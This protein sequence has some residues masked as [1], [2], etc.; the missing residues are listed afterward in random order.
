MNQSYPDTNQSIE[1]AVRAVAQG[2]VIAYPTEAVFGIG[3]DPHHLIALE[4]ILQIK[5]RDAGKGLILIAHDQAQLTG[6]MAPVEASW[7]KQFDQYWPGP[8][9]F[10]VPVCND[11]SPALSRILTGQR[12]TIAVRVSDHPVVRRLCRDCDTALVSTSANRSGKDALRSASQVHQEFG[13]QLSVVVDA[14]VG[15][16]INPSRIIDIRDGTVLR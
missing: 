7:Q 12:D 2:G 5:G 1:Q 4:R 15:D 8:V 14:P 10:I 6:F 13:T 16:Q 3:C 11:L 9:T